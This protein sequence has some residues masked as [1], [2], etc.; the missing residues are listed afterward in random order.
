MTNEERLELI[1]ELASN[2]HIT[3]I[4]ANVVNDALGDST[5]KPRLMECSGM[6]YAMNSTCYCQTGDEYAKVA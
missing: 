6:C 2:A 5:K 4:P 3:K 1:K